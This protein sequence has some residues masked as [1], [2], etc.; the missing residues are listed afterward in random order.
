MTCN[1]G[2]TRMYVFHASSHICRVNH[3]LLVRTKGKAGVTTL[4]PLYAGGSRSFNPKAHRKV[5]NPLKIILD[6]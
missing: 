3:T 2:A 6:S 5:L 4:G 1:I